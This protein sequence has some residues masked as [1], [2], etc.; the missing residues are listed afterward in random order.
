MRHAGPPLLLLALVHLLLFAASLVAGALLRH[1]GVYVNPYSTSQAVQDFFANS[2]QAI[3]ASTFFFFGSA[4]PLGLFT[5]TVVSRLRFLGVRAAGTYIALFGGF[6]ASAA[7]GISA[8]YSWILSVP[9]VVS[10][11]AAL[12]HALY[13]LSFLFGGVAFAVGFGLVAAGVSVTSHFRHLLP[14]WV[15]VLGMVIALAGELSSLSLVWYPA[16]FLL[17]LTRF[18][19]FIWLIAVAVWLPKTQATNAIEGRS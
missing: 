18:G 17:P 13:F 11:S 15:V 16:S 14:A 2:P 7:L 4:V 19:G 8:L 5:A 3:R 1:G 9:D 10:S 12:V 6:G